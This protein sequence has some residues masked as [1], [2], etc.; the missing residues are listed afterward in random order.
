MTTKKDKTKTVIEVIVFLGLL[1]LTFYL[2]Q[3][4]GY[5]V[6]EKP[7]T[8]QGRTIM[9]LGIFVMFFVSLGVHELGHLITGLVQGFQFQLFVV[10]PLGIK[11]ETDGIKVYFNK[12]LGLYGG[13][14][15][16]SPVKDDPDNPLKFARL[17]LAGPL[18]SLL[19]AILFMGLSLL[20]GSPSD[21]IFYAGG[22]MSLGIVLPPPYPP[23]Q[24]CSFL[25]AK[26]TNG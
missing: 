21:I 17:I 25:T 24:G 14:A 15:A 3:N 2:L 16:T 1:F 22:L 19:F 26:D 12:N 18:S 7:K 20:S 9:L 8:I 13:V 11:R 6:N 10:G 23:K 4:I 5:F